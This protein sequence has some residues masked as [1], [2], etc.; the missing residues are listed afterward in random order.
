[1]NN[2]RARSSAAN[3]EAVLAGIQVESELP[4]VPDVD[5]GRIAGAQLVPSVAA[6]PQSTP[7]S[8]DRNMVSWARPRIAALHFVQQVG[9][10]RTLRGMQAE[11]RTS[12]L[13]VRRWRSSDLAPFSA[14]NADA[15]VMEHFPSILSAEQSFAMV[16]RIETCFAERGYGLWALEVPGE[17]PF[18]GFV[19]LSPPDFD[20]HFTPAVEIGWRLA[21]D[22]WGRGYAIEAARAAMAFGFDEVELA[23]LVSFTTKD[24]FRSRRVMERLRMTYDPGDDFDHPRLPVSS[25]LRPH[26]L[27]RMDRPAWTAART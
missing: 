3:D 2:S 1:L 7:K 14:M 13:H 25:P 23:E 21:R 18:I 10:G 17:A 15:L 11:L 12:R 22:F 20:A 24:N 19:G 8:I 4:G 16:E 27:Y 5:R 26:V 6:H 9:L